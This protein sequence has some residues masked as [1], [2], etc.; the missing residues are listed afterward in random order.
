ME[1]AVGKKYRVKLY[2]VI[3]K[4]WNQ[5][6]DMNQWM[7]KVVTISHIYYGL[8]EG[9]L[10]RIKEDNERWSWHEHD[11]EPVDFYWDE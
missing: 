3:P 9:R 2:N 11:F 7:G 10:V 5:D 8:V 1:V 4:R 6:G